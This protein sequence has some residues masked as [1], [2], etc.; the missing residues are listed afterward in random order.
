MTSWLLP[1]LFSRPVCLPFSLPGTAPV[2]TS[3]YPVQWTGLPLRLS[4][5]HRPCPNFSLPCSVDRS[6]SP[7]LF[8]APPLSE[9]LPTLFSGPACPPPF[10]IPGTAPVRTSPYP[11]QWTGLPPRLSSWHRPCPNFS[12]PCSVDRF[13]SPSLF[14]A[15]PL[16]ELL[17]TLLSGP[18]CLPFS[19]PGTAPALTCSLCASG[20]GCESGPLQ[21]AAGR[22]AERS[23]PPPRPLADPLKLRSVRALS[24]GTVVWCGSLV[25][26]YIGPV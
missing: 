8:L 22:R 16:S 18:V 20:A 5:W 26:S 11:V 2:R 14:L 3:P 21:R 13:A 24:C 15:P 12:L 6:A 23:G 10:S 25:Q 7:S 9:L 1:T 17:P 4:S 19:I